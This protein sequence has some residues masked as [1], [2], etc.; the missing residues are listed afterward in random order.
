[1]FWLV[2]IPNYIADAWYQAERGVELGTVSL[3]HSS[4]SQEPSIA[5]NV[6][7]MKGI[8]ASVPLD[9]SCKYSNLMSNEV[10]IFSEDVQGSIAFEGLVNIKVDC[11]AKDTAQLTNSM[12]VRG[13]ET[14]Q[15]E[16][17]ALHV[18][19]E[20]NIDAYLPGT[21][22]SFRNELTGNNQKKVKRRGEKREKMEE[23]KL[24]E[25]IFECFYQ[26]PLLTL[27]ELDR[28]LE[29][30]IAYLKEVL[31]KLCIYHTSGKHRLHYE[32]KDEYKSKKMKLDLESWTGAPTSKVEAKLNIDD[33]KNGDDDY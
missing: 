22:A 12:N 21:N 14:K 7:P 19:E 3:T 9:F 5:L 16:T 8:D 32:I 29:Q 33:T 28:Q 23:T 4:A 24:E 31:N 25:L 27:V 2:K 1:M 26:K 30:P 13:L 10:K 18:F 15:K 6:K 17:R 11:F 20:K